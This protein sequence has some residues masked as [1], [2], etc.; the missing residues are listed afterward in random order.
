[1]FAVEVSVIAVMAVAA[2]AVTGFLYP[3]SRKKQNRLS[4][5]DPV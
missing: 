5:A 3:R 4:G 2:V 1:M